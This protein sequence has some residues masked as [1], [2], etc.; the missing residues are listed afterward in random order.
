MDVWLPGKTMETTFTNN[1]VKKYLNQYL[2]ATVT[3]VFTLKV[4]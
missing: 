2:D 3:E 4:F 1:T